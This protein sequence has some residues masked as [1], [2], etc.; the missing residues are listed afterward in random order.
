MLLRNKDNNVIEMKP[1]IFI[2]IKK[3]ENFHNLFY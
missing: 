1:K 2:K 3:W